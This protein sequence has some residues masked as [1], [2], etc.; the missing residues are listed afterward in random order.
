MAQQLTVLALL[1][2]AAAG[3]PF[4]QLLPFANG[5]AG[6]STAGQRPFCIPQFVTVP[7]ATVVSPLRLSSSR[8]VLTNVLTT[9]TLPASTFTEQRYATTQVS[10]AVPWMCC[11][12]SLIEVLQTERSGPSVVTESASVTTVVSLEVYLTA[13][14]RLC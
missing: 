10:L 13:S 3:S 2:A 6:N 7:A 8:P 12:L 1:A 9:E 11:S 14:A 5:T 4:P